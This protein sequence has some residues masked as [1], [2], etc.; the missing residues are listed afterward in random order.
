MSLEI[1]A[2]G[3]FVVSNGELNF[4]HTELE[5]IKPVFNL[6]PW[7]SAVSIHIQ[8]ENKTNIKIPPETFG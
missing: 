1:G 2:K 6:T 8:P 7:K 5:V 4:S 3:R